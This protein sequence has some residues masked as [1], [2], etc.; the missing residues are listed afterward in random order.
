MNATQILH[1]PINPFVKCAFNAQYQ[2]MKHTNY[3]WTNNI[4]FPFSKSWDVKFEIYL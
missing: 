2:C 3:E 1:L 4:W